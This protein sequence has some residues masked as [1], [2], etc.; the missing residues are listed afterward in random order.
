MSYTATASTHV[1]EPVFEIPKP[2][3]L[4]LFLSLFQQNQVELASIRLQC[5]PHN[6]SPSHRATGH[7]KH[8]HTRHRLHCGPWLQSM[9]GLSRVLHVVSAMH[10]DTKACLLAV[11]FVHV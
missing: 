10:R 2:T 3:I 8:F 5:H 9:V 1:K 4:F 11:E 6:R 7:R